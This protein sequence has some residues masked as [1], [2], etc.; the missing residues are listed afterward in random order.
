MT[1]PTLA[2][3]LRLSDRRHLLVGGAA[4][5]AAILVALLGLY[6]RAESPAGPP[7]PRRRAS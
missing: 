5:L 7:A 1:R 6:A 3:A 4:F 2:A